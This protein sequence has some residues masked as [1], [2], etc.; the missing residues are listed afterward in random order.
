MF[1]YESLKRG[2]KSDSEERGENP[3]KESASSDR[4]VRLTDE[5]RKSIGD[6][7]GPGQQVECDVTARMGQDGM[8]DVIEVKPKGGN[9]GMHGGD[10]EIPMVRTSPAISPS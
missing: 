3:P 2:R 5:E 1:A 10:Q 4:Q 6:S 7:Y 8:L 9:P